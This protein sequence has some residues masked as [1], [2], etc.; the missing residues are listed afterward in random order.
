MLC[1]TAE[2]QSRLATGFGQELHEPQ[3]RAV[4]AVS[5]PRLEL[6]RDRLDDG[7]AEP[8][9]DEIVAFGRRTRLAEAL[10]VVRDLDRDAVVVQLVED[11][12]RSLD[13]AV[14]VPHGVRARLRQREL[15]VGQRLLAEG[16]KPRQARQGKP[17]ER[18]VLGLG[19]D[20]QSNCARLGLTYP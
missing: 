11:L 1:W 3:T 6:V 10:P 2:P 12:D 15:E 9:L 5:R 19:R 8:A 7:D 20:G 13:V 18:D 17:A 4:A 16:T 14:G